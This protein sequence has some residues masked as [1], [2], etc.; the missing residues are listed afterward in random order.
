MCILDTNSVALNYKA[1]RT[2]PDVRFSG[3]QYNFLV[4]WPCHWRWRPWQMLNAWLFGCVFQVSR[5]RHWCRNDLLELLAGDDRLRLG[6]LTG[7][8][9]RAHGDG[10]R[11]LL[12]RPVTF[13]KLIPASIQAP[14]PEVNSFSQV[15]HTVADPWFLE[16]RGSGDLHASQRRHSVASRRKGSLFISVHEIV[17]DKETT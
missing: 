11:V 8:H 1:G 15:G 10:K 7:K 17:R 5:E 2:G 4:W 12:S 13:W 14:L 6:L 16:C 9:S 3:G